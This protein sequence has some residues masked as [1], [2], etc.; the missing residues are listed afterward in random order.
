MGHGERMG[1]VRDAR[2]TYLFLMGFGTKR[3]GAPDE[4]KVR[5][6]MVLCNGGN[7]VVDGERGGWLF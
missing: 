6:R 1:N 3:I 4:V 5:F 7:N 2:T